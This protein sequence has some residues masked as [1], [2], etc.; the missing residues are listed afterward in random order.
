MWREANREGRGGGGGHRRGCCRT[1]GEVLGLVA[2][3]KGLLA[4]AA[5]AATG[6]LLGLEGAD[7]CEAVRWDLG[8][9]GAVAHVGAVVLLAALEERLL[10]VLIGLADVTVREDRGAGRGCHCS[11]SRR[12]S[13]FAASSAAISQRWNSYALPAV[14]A[15]QATPYHEFENFSGW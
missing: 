7:A 13:S 10:L 11:E 3:R 9:G 1:L 6:C 14:S 2:P 5:L 12:M 8:H 15:S 4:L